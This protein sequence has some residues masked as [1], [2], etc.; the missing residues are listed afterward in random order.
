MGIHDA[1]GLRRRGLTR[2]HVLQSILAFAAAGGLGAVMSA[3]APQ[4]PLATAPAATPLP[5]RKGPQKLV[6]GGAIMVASLDPVTASNVW[7]QSMYGALFDTLVTRN[8]AP[9]HLTIRPR[10]A[11]SWT[12]IDPATW[13]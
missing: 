12:L 4:A 7:S 9:D 10:L 2:R 13:Q 11:T 3:C 1:R 6:Y 5:A 8:P